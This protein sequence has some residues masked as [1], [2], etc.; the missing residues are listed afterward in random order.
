MVS[1]FK[2][3]R[4]RSTAKNDDPVSLFFEVNKVFEKLVDN[5][6]LDQ[7]EKCG[8]F[9]DFLYGFRSFSPTSDLLRVVS[10]R[11]ARVFNK[12]EVT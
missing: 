2:N 5:R 8:L 4:E 7:L 11:I 12:S 3:V 10:A 1:V 9:S 6:I